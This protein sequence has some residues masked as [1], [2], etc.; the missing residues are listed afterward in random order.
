MSFSKLKIFLCLTICLLFLSGC[1][2]SSSGGNNGSSSSRL[3]QKESPGVPLESNS[4]VPTPEPAT[5]LL[6]GGG[7]IG[8]AALRKK[9]K[10]K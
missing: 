1:W 5:M 9:F 7:A 2:E 10:K 4:P 6:V 3:S 8:L